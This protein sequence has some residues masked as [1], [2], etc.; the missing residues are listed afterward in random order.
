MNALMIFVATYL[1][2]GILLLTVL[3]LVQTDVNR[4]KVLR[5]LCVSLFLAWLLGT[6]GSFVFFNPRPFVV[7]GFTPLIPHAAEN[8]FPSS[9]AL[10]TF[11]LSFTVLLFRKN[12]GIAL[13]LLSALLGIARMYV[14]VHHGIDILGGVLL[15]AIAVFL[16]FYISRILVK[17]SA[18]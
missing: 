13:I 4:W 15:A 14:G 5:V 17:D 11:T 12:W 8:G 16:A 7:G 18:D 1:H 2:L 3:F 9:H 6:I 10:Y